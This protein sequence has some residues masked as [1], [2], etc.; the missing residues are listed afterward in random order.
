M[1]V[2]IIPL[3]QV[4]SLV[5]RLFMWALIISAVMSW[6]VAFG[7]INTHNRFVYTVMD[8]L[9]RITEPFLRPLRNILP[10]TGGIDFSP[11]ALILIL[12]LVQEVLRQLVLRIL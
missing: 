6:L 7:V 11:L 12:I 9:H 8:A 2:I 5:I 1:E 3:Y 4:I 10:N